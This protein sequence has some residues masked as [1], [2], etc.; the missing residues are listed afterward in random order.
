MVFGAVGSS[1]EKRKNPPMI[2]TRTMMIPMTAPFAIL[3]R[4]ME[5]L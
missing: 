4:M 3:C 1:P 2:R 5:D